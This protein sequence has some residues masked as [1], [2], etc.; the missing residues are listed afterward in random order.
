MIYYKKIEIDNLTTIQQKTLEFLKNTYADRFFNNIPYPSFNVID[1]RGLLRSVPEL[2]ESFEKYGLTIDGAGVHILYKDNSR[3][4]KDA[5]SPT[6]TT[7]INIPILNCEGSRTQFYKGG[8][9]WVNK[10]IDE[11]YP[12]RAWSMMPSDP[13]SLMFVDQVNIDMATLLRINEPH[14]VSLPD[15]PKV[16]RITLSLTFTKDPVFLLEE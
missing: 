15:N 5:N 13:L 9:D 3:I 10:P 8:G 4:H 6:R 7:R 11:N 1:V 12:D 2:T 14:T 16:P